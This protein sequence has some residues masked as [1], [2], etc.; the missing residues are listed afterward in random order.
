MKFDCFAKTCIVLILSSLGVLLGYSLCCQHARGSSETEFA[1]L[2][3]LQE[4]QAAGK[5]PAVKQSI[6]WQD[7]RHLAKAGWP[8]GAVVY[9]SIPNCR[10]CLLI[11]RRVFPNSSVIAELNRN[12]TMVRTEDANSFAALRGREKFT[13][14]FLMFISPGGDIIARSNCPVMHKDGS[15]AHQESVEFLKLVAQMTKPPTP[16]VK[17]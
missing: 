15:Y 1:F 6:D 16:E 17:K 4:E 5:S 11:Q 14:P 12:H 7:Y 8:D 13:A 9:V 10:P 3:L 2:L